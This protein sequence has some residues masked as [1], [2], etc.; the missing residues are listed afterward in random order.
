MILIQY[1]PGIT[2]TA[3]GLGRCLKFSCN[4]VTH[5]QTSHINVVDY[6]SH[7]NPQADAPYLTAGIYKPQCLKTITSR[8]YL[9][10]PLGKPAD[11]AIYFTFRNFE[12]IRQK[13]AYLTIYLNNN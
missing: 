8:A 1:T 11:R 10:S 13:S 12:S 7:K 9:F 3:F 2:C 6:N 5:K 4:N